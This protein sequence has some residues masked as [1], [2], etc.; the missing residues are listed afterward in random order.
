MGGDDEVMKFLGCYAGKFVRY[1]E[2]EY[3][4]FVRYCFVDPMDAAIFRSRFE[5]KETSLKLAS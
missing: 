3:A 4:V 2:D 5:Q 1:I